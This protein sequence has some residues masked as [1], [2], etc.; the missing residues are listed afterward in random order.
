MFFFSQMNHKSAKLV[1][2]GPKIKMRRIQI[3]TGI[4]LILKCGG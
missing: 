3:C 2:F 1:L 4:F